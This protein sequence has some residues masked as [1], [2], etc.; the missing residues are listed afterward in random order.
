MISFIYVPVAGHKV[1]MTSIMAVLREVKE[2]SCVAG[3]MGMPEELSHDIFSSRAEREEVIGRVSEFWIQ[4]NP[5]WLQL[6]E[7]L[8]SCNEQT[9]LDINNIMES[10]N[11]E[12]RNDLYL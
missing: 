8:I 7:I 12:G 5:S 2:L 3:A 11:H 10:Y 1:T 9:A 6:R 4:K